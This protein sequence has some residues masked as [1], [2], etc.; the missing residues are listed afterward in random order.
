MD[1]GIAVVGGA[2]VR[3][4][5][6]LGKVDGSCMRLTA[7]HV[8][9]LAELGLEVVFLDAAALALDEVH[10]LQLPHVP[11]D[12]ALAE[13]RHL[14]EAR[15]AHAGMHAHQLDHA[16]RGRV[17]ERGEHALLEVREAAPLREVVPATAL[18]HRGHHVEAP[19][20]VEVVLQ[21]ARG[22]AKVPAHLAEVAAGGLR[23]E[24]HDPLP[25]GVVHE[26]SAL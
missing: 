19:E 18:L 3:L 17:L 6:E 22:H 4:G 8:E 16:P 1:G 13:A 10:L 25:E 9:H 15:L 12:G 24:V 21:R 20:D 14:H 23:E 2:S 26:I 7:H 11:R 5:G